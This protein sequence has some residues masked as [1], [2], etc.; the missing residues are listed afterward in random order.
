MSN[1]HEQD[2]RVGEYFAS[3]LNQQQGSDY[4]S[5]ANYDEENVDPDVDVYINSI[6]DEYPRL[7]SYSSL[8]KKRS[9]TRFGEI[10]NHVP[11]KKK[12]HT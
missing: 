8:H 3:W 6:T 7:L 2:Q 10:Y 9:F 1:K 4:I 12:R 11:K 5:K